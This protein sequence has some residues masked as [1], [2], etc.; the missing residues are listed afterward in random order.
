M[1]IST[2]VDWSKE[3]G[4][5]TTAIVKQ[6]PY[7][8]YG[9]FAE[10][11]I[12]DSTPVVTIPEHLVLTSRKALELAA[13]SKPVLTYISHK[14]DT[15][16]NISIL[17]ENIENERL[18]LCLF[19]IYC[20]FIKTSTYWSPYIDILP[21]ISFFEDN[22]ILFNP[23]YI[24]G[25]SLESSVRSK[26]A[27]LHREFDEIKNTQTQESW[28]SNIQFEMYLWADCVFWS[29]VVGIG[30]DE[31]E[32][33]QVSDMALIP[34]F[35]FANHSLEK[36]NIRWQLNN[37]GIDLITYHGVTVDEGEE[38]LLSYGSKPN[39][40]LLFLHGFCIENNPEPS[41][42]TIPLMPFFSPMEEGYNTPKIHW[43][44]QLGIKPSLTL[45]PR[46][47][48]EEMKDLAQ[49]GWNFESIVVMYFVAL[50]EDIDF[51]IDD[52]KF[53]FQLMGKSIQSL[54]ELEASVKNLNIFPVIQ[55]RAVVLLLDALEYHHRSNTTSAEENNNYLLWKQVSVY[56]S[57]ERSTLEKTIQ[58]LSNIKNMLM[59][60]PTVLS[61]L[62][63]A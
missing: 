57:E 53:T 27:S 51:I 23:E 9:L 1:N 24:A 3:K 56:R 30:G 62:N 37:K 54:E 58:S 39:E 36:S 35:D 20:K 28:I 5:S 45:I 17:A 4:I 29:R 55:L 46:P 7:A 48:N 14:Y 33:E 15:T 63:D 12:P 16:E 47:N 60:D 59:E 38:L 22:H 11:N 32:G 19:L 13:F 61:Y 49:C 52:D 41:R 25:T 31:K 40:E 8:G 10:T 43:L 34:F 50:E 2:F 21:T 44:K 18:V 6:T 42:L 26:L